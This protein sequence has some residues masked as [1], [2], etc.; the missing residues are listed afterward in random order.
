MVAIAVKAKGPAEKKLLNMVR[1]LPASE[2]EANLE[3]YEKLSEMQPE[4]T[5]YAKKAAFYKKQLGQGK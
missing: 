4:N 3:Q 1:K 2:L 5:Y